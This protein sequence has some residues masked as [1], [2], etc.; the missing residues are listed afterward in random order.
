[1]VIKGKSGNP[2]NQ[3]KEMNQLNG[4][5]MNDTPPVKEELNDGLVEVYPQAPS[6]SPQFV[7]N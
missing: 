7:S 5:P 3:M 4:I 2:V 6:S 1:M